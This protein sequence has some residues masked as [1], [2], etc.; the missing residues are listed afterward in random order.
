MEGIGFFESFWKGVLATS[1]LEWTAV[2]TSVVYVILATFRSIWCWLFA[3][4]SASLYVYICYTFDLFIESGLQLFYVAMAV[5]GWVSWSK[6]K[7]KDESLL[8]SAVETS[9]TRIHSWGWALHFANVTASGVLALVIGWVFENYT[10][11]AN[12]YLD[13]FT[14]VFSL[15]ATFMV[16][17]RVLEN[18]IY[19]VVIDAVSI[20]LYTSR[21]LY[22]SSVLYALFTVLAIIGFIAWF[23]EYK[24][25]KT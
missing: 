14:T 21:G 6:A 13:A 20:V 3:F 16:T 8:D 2:L 9:K 25:Q 12:P 15:L 11:Q 17:K 23:K 5:V 19:W 1:P 4:V 18:W 22:L 7:P 10:S 24:A